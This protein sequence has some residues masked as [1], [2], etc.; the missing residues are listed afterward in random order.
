MR[1]WI[2]VQVILN[3]AGVVM[4]MVPS[5]VDAVVCIFQN[6]SCCERAGA[7]L[8]RRGY[9]GWG[10]HREK[11]AVSRRAGPRSSRHEG[12]RGEARMDNIIITTLGN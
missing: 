11:P 7:Y 8:F 2:S 5:L 4:M 6:A 3:V 10:T 9:G 12:S 1:V